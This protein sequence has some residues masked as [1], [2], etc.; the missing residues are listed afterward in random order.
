MDNND[1]PQR[2]LSKEMQAVAANQN[3]S[4]MPTWSASFIN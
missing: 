4:G 1:N 3:N 2:Q